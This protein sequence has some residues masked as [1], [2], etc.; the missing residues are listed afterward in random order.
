LGRE[1]EEPASVRLRSRKG[2]GMV[3]GYELRR[4]SGLTYFVCR[5]D[6]IGILKEA[7]SEHVAQGVVFFV[8][9]EPGGRGDAYNDQ[10]LRHRT[11]EVLLTGINLHFNLLLSVPEKEKFVPIRNRIFSKESCRSLVGIVDLLIQ[12][13]AR[14]GRACTRRGTSTRV[15]QG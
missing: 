10:Y 9:G 13:A 1:D 5:E 7:S 11:N 4:L 2:I 14:V 8:E 6:D 12:H 3:E 15:E